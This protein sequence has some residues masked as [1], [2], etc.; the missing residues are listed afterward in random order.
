[1]TDK[2]VPLV[3]KQQTRTYRGVVVTI[4]Y[5]PKTNDFSWYFTQ[6]K[7][8]KMKGKGKTIDACMKDARQ[9][10]DHIQHPVPK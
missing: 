2:V 5:R 6:T 7:T 8:I 4:D 10:I 3:G 9:Y 1:M